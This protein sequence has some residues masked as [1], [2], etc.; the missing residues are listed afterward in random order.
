MEVTLSDVEFKRVYEYVFLTI[1]GIEPGWYFDMIWNK[2][3]NVHMHDGK[4]EI[5]LK[6]KKEI[7]KTE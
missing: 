2:G 4:I 7:D 3:K 6:R 1:S 5:V